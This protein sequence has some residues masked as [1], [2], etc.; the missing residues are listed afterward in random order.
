MLLVSIE[1]K[2]LQEQRALLEAPKLYFVAKVRVN[3]VLEVQ[4]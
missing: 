4:L 2:R 1:A 3:S